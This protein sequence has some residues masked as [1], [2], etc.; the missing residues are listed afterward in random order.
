DLRKYTTINSRYPE[1]TFHEVVIFL[2]IQRHDIPVQ[3]SIVCN[4]RRDRLRA[5]P[6]H[7]L[8]TVP[9]VWS[10]EAAV[11]RRHADYGIQKCSCFFD[12]GC[13]LL[14]MRF[15]EVPLKWSGLNAVDRNDGRHQR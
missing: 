6:A 8:Q 3:L 7:G 13:Q 5:K 14:V 2:H 9:A 12:D 4:E 15:R 10:P 11:L 1:I